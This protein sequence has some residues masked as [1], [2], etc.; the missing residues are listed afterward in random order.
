LQ[1]NTNKELK[2]DTIPA[3]TIQDMIKAGR[4]VEARTLLTVQESALSTEELRAFTLELEQRQAEAE[5]AISQAERLEISGKTEEAKALYESVLLFA[6]DYP[7]IQE[8]VKRMDEALLLTKAIKH[9]NRRIRESSPVPKK[10]TAGK[11]LLTL[12]GTGV[13]GGLTVAILLLLLEKPE[14]QQIPFSEK[15]SPT[16]PGQ[17][18]A[19]KPQEMK[20]AATEP[21][22]PPLKEKASPEQPFVPPEAQVSVPPMPSLPEKTQDAQPAAPEQVVVPQ[23]GL[24]QSPPPPLPVSENLAVAVPPPSLPEKNGRKRNFTYTVQVGDSLSLIAARQLCQEEAWKK[25]YQLNREQIAEP[26]RLKPGMVLRLSG[27]ENRC[28][29]V[30]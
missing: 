17:T 11:R 5:A 26:H 6:V 18:L 24:P 29:A 1:A 25:I 13:V 2:L 20:A 16:A 8:H 19:A 9:R 30:P 4:I 14:P 22:A 27:I 23:N 15:T 12:L 10:R 28:P 21:S 3:A 7:G